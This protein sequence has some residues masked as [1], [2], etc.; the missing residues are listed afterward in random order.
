MD[1]CDIANDYAERE[2]HERL[3]GWERHTCGEI[4]KARSLVGGVRG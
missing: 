2:L 4:A 3:N 1:I